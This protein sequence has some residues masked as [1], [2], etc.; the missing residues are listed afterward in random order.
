M[1]KYR[2][3]LLGVNKYS[4]SARSS[5]NTDLSFRKIFEIE[6]I[7]S[8]LAWANCKFVLGERHVINEISEKI[9]LRPKSYM[10]TKE[11]HDWNYFLYRNINLAYC[12]QW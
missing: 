9:T 2:Q 4:V 11:E 7:N 8:C 6:E 5:I 12:C 3:K 1:E 10:T